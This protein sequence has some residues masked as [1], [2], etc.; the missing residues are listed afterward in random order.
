MTQNPL[1]ILLVASEVVP[2]AKT[3]GL[4]DVAGALPKALSRRGHEVRIIMPRYKIIDEKKF[5]LNKKFDLP[6]GGSLKE[7]LMPG[8][9]IPVYFTDN[10][11]Y[12]G[13]W[14]FYGEEGEDYP[15]NGER[16][17]WF[18]KAVVASLPKLGWKPDCIHC[19]DWQSG[20]I[21]LLV[22]QSSDPEVKS[23]ATLM[24]VHN[25][26]YQGFFK[27]ELI[28]FIGF[29]KELYTPEGLEYWG[30]F[31]FLKAGLLYGDLLSTVSERYAFEIKNS[32]EYGRGM[33]GVLQN[34]QKDL[35]G[36]VNGV[37]Y[38]EWDPLTDK[39]LSLNYGPDTVEKKFAN[40]RALLKELKMVSNENVPLLAMVSRLD[41]QKGLDLVLGAIEGLLKLKLQLVLLGIGDRKY[42]PLLETLAKQHPAKLSV[43]LNFNDPLGHEIYAGA[44]IFLM[45][46][47]FEP[48][49]LGQL[50]AFKYGTIPV[51]RATGGL[52]DTVL[53]F[54]GKSEEGN[55]FV[56]EDYTP[57]AFLEAVRQAV[58]VFTE[59]K[60]WK[61]LM[62]NAMSADFSW[63]SSARKYEQLYGRALKRK[64]LKP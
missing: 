11:K 41:D 4:A 37:D 39:Y 59:K 13:R 42:Y 50:V 25:I 21:P 51:V 60:N 35:F 22:K 40:K 14:G 15:D 53:K 44:D 10:D 63:E 38:E 7:T 31:S 61:K 17:T 57:E 34:R 48:C 55:G 16:F 52:Y 30:G 29:P 46:S 28:D 58:F 23:I 6:G 43:N 27:K 33:E 1:K 26:A 49:G 8:T 64:E 56:F 47:K 12:F 24:T 19:N 54:D 18:N 62:Q 9:G 32:A 36:I 45:P 2:F 3:G 20:L 5:R